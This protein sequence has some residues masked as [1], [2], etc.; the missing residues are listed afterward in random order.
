MSPVVSHCCR[1][2]LA[3]SFKILSSS[4]SMFPVVSHSCRVSLT[5]T[6][7]ILESPVPFRILELF[8][9]DMEQLLNPT[10]DSQ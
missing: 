3:V 1:V 5:I 4:M 7:S 9:G 10:G 2:I 8:H 6:F